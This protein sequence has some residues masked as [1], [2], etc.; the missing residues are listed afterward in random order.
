MSIS[1][2]E[3]N[4]A[5]LGGVDITISLTAEQAEAIGGE[6]GPLADA[7]A[8]ALWALA[9]LRTD[10]VPADQDDGPGARPDRPATADTWVNAIHDVEQR[11]LPRLE[12]IRDAAMRAHAASGGSY[13][14]LA[15]ALGVTA[16]STAQYRRDTLQAR[17]PSEWEI[18]ALTGKRPTQD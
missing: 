13:G 14:Q 6:L 17:M 5:A 7:M 9:V 2:R 8:G 4:E 12:G 1:F 15:R 11:L 10:T 18:W 16:R 3:G